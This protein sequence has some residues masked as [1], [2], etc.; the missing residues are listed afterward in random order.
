MKRFLFAVLW[1]AA[2]ASAGA[3]LGQRF[4]PHLLPMAPLYVGAAAGGGVFL[5]LAGLG[6]LPGT[7]PRPGG[8]VAWGWRQA[9]WLLVQFF[10][11]QLAAQVLSMAVLIGGG[12]LLA[13]LNHTA[14]AHGFGGAKLVVSTLV[15]YLGAAGWSVWYISRLGPVR[16]ADG[17]PSGI[18]WCA[19]PRQAYG[20]AIGALLLVGLLSG[21]VQHVLPPSAAAVK[22]DPFQQLFGTQGW[23]LGVL[24][25]LAAVLAPFTEELVFR[26][27][28]FAALSGSCGTFGA[29]VL[30]SILFTGAHAQEFAAYKPGFI[31]I[32]AVAVVLAWL[33][34]KYRSI[35]PGIL[36]HI[37]FNGMS[38]LA[39]AFSH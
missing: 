33:R 21:L 31:V 37:L 5:T 18:G 36:L 12:I 15:G 26:G 20:A 30:T 8:A 3:A 14:P 4:V 17:S 13:R 7:R 35:R 22:N 19:A 10:N 32:G 29:A 38:V 2:L 1:A 6:W 11:M 23:K 24:F 9:V 28:V 25:L 39:V 34:I 27:G 16:L